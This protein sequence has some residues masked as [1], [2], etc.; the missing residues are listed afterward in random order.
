MLDFGSVHVEI[1]DPRIS[2]LLSRMLGSLEVLFFLSPN[3]WPSPSVLGGFFAKRRW[4]NTSWYW[5]RYKDRL[6]I[7]RKGRNNFKNTKSFRHTKKTILRF[8][9]VFPPI[10][11]EKKDGIPTKHGGCVSVLMVVGFRISPKWLVSPFPT[12]QPS[13][14]PKMVTVQHLHTLALSSL[15]E[16]CVAFCAEGFVG[17]S[18]ELS[19][20]TG[21]LQI[22]LAGPPWKNEFAKILP[23]DF[24]RHSQKGS[25]VNHFPPKKKHWNFS[26]GYMMF[27]VVGRVVL[28]GF[29]FVVCYFC[30][31]LVVCVF[32]GL[33]EKCLLFSE[34]SIN[35]NER[36]K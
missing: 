34:L 2:E 33:E 20:A 16:V 28:V 25:E 22:K 19:C 31:L 6:R 23:S 8:V 36:K 15:L 9:C 30:Y 18:T 10:F 13:T 29:V 11:L 14:F 4:T 35:P 7:G 17:S 5:I 26:G 24:S 32:W 1:Q 12:L 27:R 21:F 3:R